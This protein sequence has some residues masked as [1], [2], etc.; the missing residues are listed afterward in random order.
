MGSFDF[1]GLTG[2]DGTRTHAIAATEKAAETGYPVFINDNTEMGERLYAV[3]LAN[4]DY[5]LDAFERREDAICF[6]TANNLVCEVL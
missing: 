5:W 4:T 2:R 3:Q 1:T 6:I